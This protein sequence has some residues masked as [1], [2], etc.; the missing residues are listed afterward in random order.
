MNLTLKNIPAALHN[1]LKENAVEHGQSLSKEILSTLESAVLPGKMKEEDFLDQVRRKR[2]NS[3]IS[4]ALMS[5]PG[6]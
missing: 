2:R 4:Y 1:A 3:L 5:E 6:N